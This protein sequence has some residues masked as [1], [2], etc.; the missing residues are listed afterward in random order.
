MVTT[1]CVVGRLKRERNHVKKWS[2]GIRYGTAAGFLAI[3]FL[4]RYALSPLLDHH[5]PFLFF[6][7]AAMLA[8]LFGGV[9]AGLAALVGGM[10]IGDFF[11]FS[12]SRRLRA[13]QHHRIDGARQLS[14]DRIDWHRYH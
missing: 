7:P 12:A 8:S 9:S 2:V 5:S 6:L 10:L 1:A 4:I 3:A 14:A 13:V 11:F